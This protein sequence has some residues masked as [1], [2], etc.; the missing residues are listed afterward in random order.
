MRA[1]I[2]NWETGI[3][4]SGRNNA[5]CSASLTLCQSVN[6]GGPISNSY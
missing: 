4:K 2:Y 5:N 3:E 6:G 1:N